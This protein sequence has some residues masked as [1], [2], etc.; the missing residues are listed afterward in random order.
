VSP[1]QI[2]LLF[3]RSAIFLL[4]CALTQATYLQPGSEPEIAVDVNQNLG[5]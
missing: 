4:E 5:R 2:K 1:E 3:P